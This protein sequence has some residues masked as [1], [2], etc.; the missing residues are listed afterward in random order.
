VF[1]TS[2]LTP[3]DLG[4]IEQACEVGVD[5]IALSYVHRAS[6]IEE[7]RSLVDGKRKGIRICAKIETRDALRNIVSIADAS[8]LLMVARGDMG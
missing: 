1:H 2:G 5:F 8:D 7:L 4:D 6:D 3:K